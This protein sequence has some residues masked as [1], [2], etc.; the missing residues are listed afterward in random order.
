VYVRLHGACVGCP[1]SSYTLKMGVQKAIKEA[2][3]EVQMV[4]A[5]DE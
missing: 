3:P 4:E 1:I 2:V 5:L